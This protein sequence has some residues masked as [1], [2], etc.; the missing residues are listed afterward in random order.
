[1]PLVKLLEGSHVALSGP[2]S[3]LVISFLV[4]LDFGCGHVFVLGQATG[5]LS[6]SFSPRLSRVRLFQGSGNLFLGISHL[7]CE[8]LATLN[9]GVMQRFERVVALLDPKDIEFL[10]PHQQFR[11]FTVQVQ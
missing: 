6:S 5:E 1:M 8:V 4:R 7:V 11:E 9:A 2:L 3:Q 10:P